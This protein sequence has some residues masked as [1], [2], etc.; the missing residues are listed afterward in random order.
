[1][2][3]ALPEAEAAEPPPGTPKLRS[4]SELPGPGPLRF[5]YQLFVKGYLLHLPKLQVTPGAEGFGLQSGEWE[6]EGGA[7]EGR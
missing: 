5:L 7:R 6:K 4:L 2:P 3:A 1:M